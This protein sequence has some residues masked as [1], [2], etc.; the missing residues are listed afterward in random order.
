[1]G[2]ARKIDDNDDDIP[3]RVGRPRAPE[4]SAPP[5]PF[6]REEFVKRLQAIL[7]A[8]EIP[9]LGRDERLYCQRILWRTDRLR[10]L[11]RKR[12]P[13]RGEDQIILLLRSVFETANGAGALTLPI[14]RAVSGCMYDRWTDRGLAWLE[15]MDAVPLLG[16]FQTLR[17]LGLQDRLED[18]IRFK[19]TQILGS[20]F[21]PPAK[22]PTRKMVKPPTVSQATW[23][24]ML[25]LRKDDR[26]RR[27]M[28]R[29]S[30]R[31][32]A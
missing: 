12:F 27:E 15:A 13:V 26:R 6:E 22:E 10:K 25:Q 20:P 23:D 32:A 5:E 30:V 21:S 11:D 31:M 8:L 17:D 3:A 9:D 28:K 2:R 14:L 4:Q 1:M 16:I 24:E 18:A 19:L 29:K 7:D